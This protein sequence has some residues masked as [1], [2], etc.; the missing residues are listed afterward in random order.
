[1]TLADSQQFENAQDFLRRKPMARKFVVL[2]SE[3]LANIVKPENESAPE[4][5]PRPNIA[6]HVLGPFASATMAEQAIMNWPCKGKHFIV[7][8]ILF[9]RFTV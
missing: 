3:Q 1:M 5:D 6:G 2:C 9:R 8:A 4:A 7:E